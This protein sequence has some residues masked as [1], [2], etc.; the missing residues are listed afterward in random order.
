[1]TLQQ[2][3]TEMSKPYPQYESTKP[4]GGTSLTFISWFHRAKIL[5]ELGVDWDKDIQDVSTA[6]KRIYIC[7]L[8]V[9]LEDTIATR[10]AT[11]IEDDQTSSYGDPSSNAEAM[12]FSRATAQFGLGLYL[13]EKGEPKAVPMSEPAGA[14]MYEPT[15]VYEEDPFADPEP[16]PL[17]DK[18]VVCN[19]KFDSKNGKYDTC[20]NCKQ[21]KM[22]DECPSCG[23]K[24]D[25]N[26]GKYKTCYNCK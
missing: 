10:S 23:N 24:Y 17:Q 14:P 22:K 18:C 3:V 9:K 25:S 7:K 21:A 1:M 8:T 12:A 19:G 20:Y 26:G 11:G 16:S 15:P 5:N 13:Y 6:D 4:A 2:F